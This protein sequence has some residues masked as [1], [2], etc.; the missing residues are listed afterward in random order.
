MRSFEA[1]S[2]S[3]M[4]SRLTFSSIIATF[5]LVLPAVI[6]SQPSQEKSIAA[7]PGFVRFASVS[8]GEKPVQSVTVYSNETAQFKV[9]DITSPVAWITVK[10]RKATDAERVDKGKPGNAQYRVD[11]LLDS[12]AAAIGPIAEQISIKTNSTTNPKLLI[13][14]SGSIRPAGLPT[15]LPGKGTEGRIA[16]TV[17]DAAGAP[18]A[19]VKIVLTRQDGVAYELTKTSASD[20]YFGFLIL[21]ATAPYKI[22]LEK[23][24]Y[25]PVDQDLSLKARETNRLSYTLKPAP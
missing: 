18:I 5:V 2:S 3:E 10:L 25:M 12:T 21:D 7:E 16:G 13:A 15:R 9:L 23:A 22:H 1:L 8:Q 17:I 14:V 24:G 20:G 11:V 19:G 6:L 4:N